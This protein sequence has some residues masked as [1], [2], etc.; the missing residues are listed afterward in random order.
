MAIFTSRCPDCNSIISGETQAQANR[1]LGLHRRSKHGYKSPEYAE[2]KAYR[3]AAKAKLSGITDERREQLRK[4]REARWGRQ[5]LSTTP[6]A[7]EKRTLTKAGSPEWRAK[8]KAYQDAYRAKRKAAM[9]TVARNNSPDAAQPC[10]LP[11][12]PVCGSAF[13][14]VRGQQSG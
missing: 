6:A 14:V 13:Y 9:E 7:V 4:A 1:N 3:E 11:R 12:C 2:S 8:R 5:P 10:N